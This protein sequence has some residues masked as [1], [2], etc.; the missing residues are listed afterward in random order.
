M[1]V[2]SRRIG[3]EIMLG[4]NIRVVV[5]RIAGNRVTIGI[6]APREVQ[7]VRGELIPTTTKDEDE[8]EQSEAA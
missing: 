2:L 6:Q 4:D 3:E 7:I 1:L 8:S 5:N